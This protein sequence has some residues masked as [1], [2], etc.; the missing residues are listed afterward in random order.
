MHLPAPAFTIQQAHGALARAVRHGLSKEQKSLPCTYLYDARGSA[1]FEAICD[2]PEYGLSRAGLRLLQE[3]AADLLPHLRWPLTVVELGS[4]TATKTR[5]LLT[6]LGAAAPTP[7]A[8]H[9]I[10]ISAA[11]LRLCAEN[12]RD[13]SNLHVRTHVNTYLEALT[14]IVA[15]RAPNEQL[16]VLFLGS[17]LGNFTPLAA[18]RF[19]RG[20]C[21]RLSPGD[22][23]LLGTDL[24]Q[25]PAQLRRAY[26]DAT[27]ITAAFNLNLL[28]RLNRELGATF[29]VSEFAHQVRINDAATCVQMHLCA[30]R[31]QRVAIPGAGMQVR[32]AADETIWTESS[33]K[34]T[35]TGVR[36]L[37]GAAG[38][39]CLKQWID[40]TW[41][42]AHSLL[43]YSQ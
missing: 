3:H 18:Q 32:F 7:L 1:L 6:T 28:A 43:A 42:F 20:V 26:D 19:L 34:F 9:A 15:R 41:P 12:L 24:N 10:D 14:Q 21:R 33:H 39:H 31:P 4:G 5:L 17:T 40:G 13:L 22:R 8:Y 2:L 35:C 23:L 25:D 29:D 27:G 36:R 11:A 38:L 30:R 37:A 16:L